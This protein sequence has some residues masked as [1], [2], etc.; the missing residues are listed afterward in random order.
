MPVSPTTQ[1]DDAGLLAAYVAGDESAIRELV[2]RHQ[3][4]VYGLCYRYF[5]DHTDAEDATQDTFL[6]LARSA[7][8]F[9]GTASVASWLTRVAINA[10]HDIVRRR[11]VRPRAVAHEVPDFA[12]PTDDV[13]AWEAASDVQRALA[14]LDPQSRSLLVLVAVEGHSYAE[15]AD[16][17]GVSV[18][19]AKSRVHRARGRLSDLL[20]ERRLVAA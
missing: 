18:A 7:A 17:V 4:R 14:R 19:A 3:R 5:G 12:D 10:C 1:T 2:E 6:A 20:V 8:S 15:A 11:E 9:R 13:G 16:L